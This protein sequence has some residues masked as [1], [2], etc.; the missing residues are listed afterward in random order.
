MRIGRR[1]DVEQVH[2]SE[3][4]FGVLENRQPVRP[5]EGLATFR[6]GGGH[7]G[8]LDLCAVNP[9]QTGDVVAGGKPGTDNSNANALHVS[10]FGID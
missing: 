7:P 9:A 2:V 1:T 8:D 5:A 10:A 3:H 4:G 6:P